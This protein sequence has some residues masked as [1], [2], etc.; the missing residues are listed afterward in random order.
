MALT[1]LLLWLALL[2]VGFAV[3]GL[4]PR[5][6]TRTEPWPKWVWVCFG[7]GVLGLAIGVPA[8]AINFSGGKRASE[9]KSGIVLSASQVEGRDLFS[10]TCKRC[11]TLADAK[12]VSTIGPNLDQ[13]QPPPALV[14]NAVTEGRARGNGNMPRGLTD[15][16]GA[17][18]VAA[19]LEAVAGQEP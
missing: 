2:V 17:R 15:A 14:I 8:A 1:F 19:Y 6:E 12:S 11:H 7:L 4:R 10:S 18:G 3:Y 16:A 9:T 13:L 5:P